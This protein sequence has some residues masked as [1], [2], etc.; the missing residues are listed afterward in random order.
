M[1]KI[2][3]LLF[4]LVLSLLSISGVDALVKEDSSMF[5]EDTYIIGITKF[6]KN[7][8]VNAS[9]VNQA[10]IDYA[11]FM[12]SIN[13][14]SLTSDI[15]FYSK[16]TDE[17][18]SISKN[19]HDYKLLDETEVEKLE[20]NLNVF[21]VNNE[22]KMVNLDYDG[23]V[24]SISNSKVTFENGKFIIPATT[25]G[26][27]FTSNNNS[28]FDVDLVKGQND[29]YNYGEY[30]IPY[31]VNYFDEN[32]NFIKGI[33]TNKNG[34]L[35]KSELVVSNRNGY[36]HE[37]V[38]EADQIIDTNTFIVKNNDVKI[39][40]KWIKVGSLLENNVSEYNEDT[41]TLKYTGVTNRDDN[42]NYIDITIVA[43]ENFDP[44]NTLVNDEKVTWVDGMYIL[45]LYLSDKNNKEIVVKWDDQDTTT[46]TIDL[47]ESKFVYVI[48]YK[49]GYSTKGS[50]NVIEGNKLSNIYSYTKANHIFVGLTATKFGTVKFDLDT[51]ITK[52][53]TFY[54]IYT[55]LVL[56]F[57]NDVTKEVEYAFFKG[58]ESEQKLKI[59]YPK[60]NSGK[61]KLIV[62]FNN[63]ND[64]YN[65]DNY[66][67]ANINNE[68]VDFSKGI[69]ID[70]NDS[71]SSEIPF[72]VK[73]TTNTSTSYKYLIYY[74]DKLIK[75][76]TLVNGFTDESNIVLTIG[77]YKF[78]SLKA[79]K[80]LKYGTREN[81][82]KLLDDITLTGV[83]GITGDSYIDLNG[84]TLTSSKSNSI[85][86][87]STINESNNYSLN[88]Y[89]GKLNSVTTKNETYA[90]KGGTKSGKGKF[91]LKMTDVIIDSNNESIYMGGVNSEVELNNV[92][93]NS[94]NNAFF[95]EGK[96]SKVVI[97]GSNMNTDLTAIYTNGNT[98]V[99]TDITLNNSEISS[100]TI[101]IFHASSGTLKVLDSK[102]TGTAGIGLKSGSLIVNNSS[103]IAN[104]TDPEPPTVN[105]NGISNTGDAIYV[106]INKAYQSVTEEESKISIS[107]IGSE[108]NSLNRNAI[109]IF[110][111]DQIQGTK[112]DAP[113]YT[114]IDTSN[115]TITYNK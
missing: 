67:K 69:I 71:Q 18:F 39:Y 25:L 68:W 88:I 23:D 20:N 105:N 43:P 92:T 12:Q 31:I 72:K 62:K 77:D 21:Y 26:F 82:V 65:E 22:E 1:N 37:F 7:V 35:N 86:E 110:N 95:I 56:S 63:T 94:K 2:R 107:V 16:L 13:N 101:G 66:I 98:A 61:F 58:E 103:I 76:S 30:Y 112:V 32:K 9:M 57:N 52:D 87:F 46:F 73:M 109:R 96:N 28:I 100:K 97:N 42:G 27:N 48:T 64:I 91:T 81:P 111:P 60:I 17:W 5:T 83:A 80:L 93:I 70:A 3:K 50:E 40:D 36:K 102:I 75:E 74:N 29:N 106:E 24:S 53:Y 14:N 108:L 78:T 6:D 49:D 99:N 90:I 45:R 84:K 15:Y 11:N 55:S 115:D 44:T 10:G 51:P 114:L 104:D 85:I 54:P 79:S 59:S 19:T 47:S 89:N 41:L 34:S 4:T 33:K 113:D 38:D 8:I